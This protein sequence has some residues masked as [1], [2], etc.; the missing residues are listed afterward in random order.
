MKLQDEL[1]LYEQNSVS[2]GAGGM[3]SAP[4]TEITKL[5][6]NVKPL[7]GSM[8]MNFQQMNGVQGYEVTIRTDFDR[9]PDRNYILGYIGIYGERSLFILYPVI[10]KHY[11]KFICKGENKLPTTVT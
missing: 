2:D 10:D 6:G 4:L 5:W 11:T 9:L 8:G 3:T 7:S 1:I